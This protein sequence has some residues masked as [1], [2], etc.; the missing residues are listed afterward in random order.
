MSCKLKLRQ[1]KTEWLWP[2][3]WSQCQAWLCN[4]EETLE[5]PSWKLQKQLLLKAAE[6]CGQERSFWLFLLNLEAVYQK[7]W[8]RLGAAHALQERQTIRTC[9]MLS[10]RATVLTHFCVQCSCSP[11][12]P[13]PLTVCQLFPFIAAV[14]RAVCCHPISSGIC[15]I[16]NDRHQVMA[17]HKC[18]ACFKIPFHSS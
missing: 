12:V 8:R 3:V 18:S 10:V 16:R 9:L 1:S 11:S 7:D 6:K 13:A 14:H 2:G 15:K 17:L 5:G 4:G